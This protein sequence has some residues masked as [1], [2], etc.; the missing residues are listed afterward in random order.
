LRDRSRAVL[1]RT[2]RINPGKRSWRQ[3]TGCVGAYVIALYAIL[4]SFMPLAAVGASVDSFGVEICHH[5]GADPALPA[6]H[7]DA[8]GHCKLCIGTGHAP[9]AALPR[10]PL[11][12]VVAYSDLRWSIPADDLPPRPTAF[13]A[14]PRGPPLQA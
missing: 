7:S 9:V 8:N 2:T 1:L 14:Q 6:D 13:S 3:L 5:D 10:A 12:F 11:P 4:A